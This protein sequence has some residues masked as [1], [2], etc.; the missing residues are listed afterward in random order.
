MAIRV[1]VKRQPTRKDSADDFAWYWQHVIKGPSPVR[2]YVFYPGRKYPFDLAWPEQKIAVE[3]DGAT[4]VRG[5]HARGGGIETDS[6]KYCLGASL[7]WRIFRIT[8]TMLRKDPGKWCGM[9]LSALTSSSTAGVDHTP[10][11]CC[12]TECNTD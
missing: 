2:E 3:I 9:V 1:R 11:I 7:G 5:R 4:W 6:E 10:G 12:V 8:T